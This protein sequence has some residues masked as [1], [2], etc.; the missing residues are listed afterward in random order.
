MYDTLKKW[1]DDVK[2]LNDK[3]NALAEWDDYAERLQAKY[4]QL[5]QEKPKNEEQK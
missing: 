1:E 3:I 5:L 4:D 2:K